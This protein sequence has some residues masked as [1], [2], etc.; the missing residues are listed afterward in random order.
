[1]GLKA[2]AVVFDLFGTLV[3]SFSTNAYEPCLTAMAADLG[4]PL[5]SFRRVWNGQLWE[6]RV[7]GRFADAQESIAKACHAIDA[8]PAWDAV[9]RA[10]KRRLDYE[11]SLLT[12]FDDVLPTFDWLH[13]RGLRLGLISNCAMEL[14][15]LWD[16]TELARGLDVSVLSA[17]VH[18]AK[19]DPRIY[20]LAC[21][22]LEV[23]PK[24][25]LYVGDGSD[26]ELQGAQAV[27]MQAV[28]IATRPDPARRRRPVPHWDGPRIEGCAEIKT[29]LA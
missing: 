7:M 5:A 15:P 8:H 14:V 25:C 23:Q 11:R 2:E 13:G 3:P 22:R 19:P 21:N 10:L 17:A 28:L 16:E 6:D 24:D 29:L 9:E 18:L 20:E 12:P 26:D 4:V 27:G 1:M